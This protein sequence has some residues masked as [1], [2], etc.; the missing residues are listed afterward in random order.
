MAAEE[1]AWTGRSTGEE[2]E[3]G[4]AHLVSH[5][6]VALSRVAM[7]CLCCVQEGRETEGA[8]QAWARASQKQH[9]LVVGVTTGA[10]RGVCVCVG[11]GGKLGV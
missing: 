10:K 1:A 8:G 5:L 3:R 4:M 9:T 6:E 2:A 7:A 11:A